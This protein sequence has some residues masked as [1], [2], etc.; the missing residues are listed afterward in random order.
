MFAPN[1]V[2]PPSPKN[3]ACN[4]NTIDN[5]MIAAYGLQNI[6]A[7]N[8]APNKCPLD[9]NGTGRL[10]DCI[11]N[12]PAASTANSGTYFSSRLSLL[13]FMERY[14]NIIAI[15]YSIAQSG[16]DIKPSGMC[17]FLPPYFIF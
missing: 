11:A 3:N 8:A 6:I 5:T 14:K 17:N 16:I 10:K 4:T 13:H 2:I 9:P 1:A 15:M 7:T 12:I